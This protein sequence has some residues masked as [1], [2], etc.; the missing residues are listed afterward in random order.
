MALLLSVVLEP[1]GGGFFPPNLRTATFSQA[2]RWMFFFQHGFFEELLLLL[3][4]L[5]ILN[6]FCF[7]LFLFLLYF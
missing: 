1:N 6:Y 3:L 7:I 4:I 5:C 2:V